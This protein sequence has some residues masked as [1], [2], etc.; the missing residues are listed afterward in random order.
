MSP[1]CL[2]LDLRYRAFVAPTLG[3]L[4]VNA[5]VGDEDDDWLVWLGDPDDA[6][7]SALVTVRRDGTVVDVEKMGGTRQDLSALAL[8]PTIVASE[9]VTLM[10]LPEGSCGDAYDDDR[11][12]LTFG[13]AEH[14]RATQV[15]ETGVTVLFDGSGGL[16]ELLFTDV[17][18]DDTFDSIQTWCDTHGIPTAGG[19][20]WTP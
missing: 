3:R 6:F 5:S 16:S 9:D 8:L 2:P 10:A 20:G 14:V 1:L 18:H 15:G 4:D 13:T 17:V 12:L 7:A 11:M 19:P